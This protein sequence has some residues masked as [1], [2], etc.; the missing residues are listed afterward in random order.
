M[1]T[2]PGTIY[3]GADP[4]TMV[5]IEPI[6]AKITEYSGADPIPSIQTNYIYNNGSV[7]R[8]FD[9]SEALQSTDQYKI[10]DNAPST[11]AA[12]AEQTATQSI[13]SEQHNLQSGEVLQ[14][15]SVLL[16]NVT[17]QVLTLLSTGQLDR[18]EN[19]LESIEGGVI[20]PEGNTLYHE[21]VKRQD[22]RLLT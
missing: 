3:N 5:E 10:D 12:I 18:V 19:L 20:D 14:G 2:L 16:E 22:F 4:V 7:G 17:D 6:P 11:S 21:A 9:G 8:V 15:Q 1:D 13:T